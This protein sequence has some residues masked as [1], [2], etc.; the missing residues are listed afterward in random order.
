ML[1]IMVSFGIQKVLE[2]HLHLEIKLSA[3][4]GLPPVGVCISVEGEER[5]GRSP[6]MG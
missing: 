2:L 6:F 3:E 4:Y 1:C 5:L